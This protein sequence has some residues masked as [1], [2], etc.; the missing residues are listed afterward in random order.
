MNRGGTFQQVTLHPEPASKNYIK[1]S[2]FIDMNNDSHWDII[3]FGGSNSWLYLNDGLGNFKKF[4]LSI[5]A[6]TFLQAFSVSD[7]NQDGFP[8]L[9]LAQLWDEYP[10]PKPNYLFLNN[11][12]LDFENVTTRLY[13]ES[14]E[15]YNFPDGVPCDENIRLT[16]IPNKNRNRRS[17][18]TQF[19]DY[20]QDGDDDLYIANYF[21]ET[22]EFYEN[23]GQGFFTAIPAPKPLL[24]SD[25]MSNHGTGVSWYDFD[26]DGDFDVLI[27]QLA[28]PRNILKYDH[29]GTTLYENENGNFNDVTAA[30][31][32]QFEETH[33][34]A[35][36]GDFNNDGLVDLI[37]T[38]Y[39]GCR[40]VDMYLQQADHSFQ[41]NTIQSGFDKL[42][43]GT[44]VNYVDYNN[45]GNLDVAFAKEG[46][47]RLYKNVIPSSNN[48]LKLNVRCT[49]RNHFGIGSIVKVYSGDQVYTQE[50]GLGKGQGMQSP[51]TLHFGLGA[52]NTVDRVE[53]L[54]GNDI[55]SV[56]ENLE[57]N[58][59]YLLTEGQLP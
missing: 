45:D 15:L 29:R 49:S 19:I 28:H 31:G 43:N 53:L 9:V 42:S 38:V 30:S 2:L 58:K 47:F 50:V 41:L 26:N 39:Y 18:G 20:D 32:I 40:F 16:K 8:D 54:I 48:W 35:N 36:F 3:L 17:R 4:S 59:T 33:A 1:R 13:P 12:A 55:I 21:L 56:V 22:D 10:V 34:G 46:N 7:I 27:P 25:S 51:S 24:Q 57:A 52:S 5:P 11:G 37:T 6:V 44:D 23:N 14:D